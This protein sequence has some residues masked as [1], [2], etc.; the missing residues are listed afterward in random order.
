MGAS[1]GLI[2]HFAMCSPGLTGVL[3]FRS[4]GVSPLLAQRV[5]CAVVVVHVQ[6]RT[7]DRP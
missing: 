3:P 1:R 6:W 7:G 5:D 4:P 2:E